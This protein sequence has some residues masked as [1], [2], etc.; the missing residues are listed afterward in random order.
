MRKCMRC[1]TEMFG[2][3]E[4]ITNEGFGLSVKEKGLFKNSLGKT[5]CAVCKDCGYVEIY[6]ENT[7]KIRNLLS[8]SNMKKL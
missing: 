7:D 4:I 3:L 6:L 5:K 8:K 2:D 1:Q